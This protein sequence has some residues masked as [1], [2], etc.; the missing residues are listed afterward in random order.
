MLNST[1]QIGD[2]TG[3]LESDVIDDSTCLMLLEDVR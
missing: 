1:S 2:N 3:V